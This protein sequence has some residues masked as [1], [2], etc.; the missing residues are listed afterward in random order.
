MLD[1]FLFQDLYFRF[2]DLS[3]RWIAHDNWTY[4]TTFTASTELRWISLPS[5][6]LFFYPE[7]DHNCVFFCTKR[8]KG[9]VLLVFDGVDTV[10]SIW[11]NGIKVGSTDNMFRRYVRFLGGKQLSFLA[12]FMHAMFFFFVF[13][14]DF[15]VGDLL[16]DGENKLEVCFQSPVL[17]ALQRFKAHSAYRVPPECPPEVQKG[18]CH[19]NFIRKVS[20]S[21]QTIVLY[22]ERWIDYI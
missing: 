1:G 5:T 8:A 7:F 21:C 11:F 19:V 4:A 22:K 9:K 6:F 12:M 3:Y 2:N 16:K 10:S 18:E 14:Q 17:Y 15:L 13:M 20:V